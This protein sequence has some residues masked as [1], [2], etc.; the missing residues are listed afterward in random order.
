M[1][2]I[3]TRLLLPEYGRNVQRMV[4]F[5]KTIEDREQRNEQARIVVAIM[6]NLYPYKR[7][8]EEFRNMLWDHLF[9]IAD[10]DIDIDCP[11]EKPT[12]SQFSP[13]PSRI[14]Y[15]QHYISQ[16]HYG[17]LVKRTLKAVSACDSTLASDEQ[18][19]AVAKNIAQFMRQKSF[20]YNKEYPSIDVV[21][22]DM[23][24]IS[25]GEF[26]LTEDVFEKQNL[27]TTS[28]TQSNSR[29]NKQQRPQQGNKNNKKQKK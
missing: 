2:P 17:S 11:F 16:K 29:N 6:G 1:K 23:R 21:I 26:A 25:D 28:K 15:A 27:Q 22:A 19:L 14:P 12:P 13:S 18:K 5:L 10:F 20:D 9:M 24:D 4:R 7:D 3:K 8:T